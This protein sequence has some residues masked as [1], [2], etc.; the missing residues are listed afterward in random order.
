M[1]S[2][3]REKLKPTTKMR[4]YDSVAMA[5]I[6][7]SDWHNISS[8]RTPAQNP[9]YCYCWAFEGNGR[10]LL[11]LWYDELIFSQNTI[12][13]QGNVR[14]EYGVHD[15]RANDQRNPTLK[16]RFKTWATRA[17]QMDEVLKIAYRQDRLIRIAL[18][19]SKKTNRQDDE[20]ATADFRLLDPEPWQLIS[21]EML[22]GA[23]H[24]RRGVECQEVT[25]RVEALSDE[26]QANSEVLVPTL[27]VITTDSYGVGVADQ[28]LECQIPERNVVSAFAWERNAK[29]R[30]A[31]LARSQ[32]R[33]EFCGHR[34]F[35]KANGDIYLETHHVVPLSEHG[36]DD[37]GNVIA[38]CPEHHREA[39][40][41]AK[42]ELLRASFLQ[43]LEAQLSRAPLMP[44]DRNWPTD[45][46]RE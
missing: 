22:T 8:K 11:C 13:Y 45:V 33:C 15:A 30:Q 40:Y 37:P 23:F 10:V 35:T 34:G 28:F 25:D 12:E 38:L 4:V 7:V 16:Q 2:D 20:R 19:Q 21:Y 6:D 18:V 31:V 26:A 42:R 17:L 29:V 24:L 39:H 27:P 3:L 9:K 46:A 36:P 41:G 32:G 1:S 14:F 5:G 44:S 43:M